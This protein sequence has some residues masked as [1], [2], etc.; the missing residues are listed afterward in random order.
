MTTLLLNETLVK[1]PLLSDGKRNSFSLISFEIG[2]YAKRSILSLTHSLTLSPSIFL[3]DAFRSIFIIIANR[4]QYILSTHS[5]FN[6]SHT[7]RSLLD[8]RRGTR[9]KILLRHF[10][11][12]RKNGW[13]KNERIKNLNTTEFQPFRIVKIFQWLTCRFYGIVFIFK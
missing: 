1:F 12:L 6:I 8:H 10:T 5:H 9:V 7:F 2:Q 11:S 13:K 3:S 4:R